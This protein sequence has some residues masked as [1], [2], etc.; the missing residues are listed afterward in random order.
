MQTKKLNPFIRVAEAPYAGRTGYRYTVACADTGREIASG[1]CESEAVAQ[2]MA[3]RV[4]K[5]PT[6]P[7]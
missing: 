5:V 7:E 1:W 6:K 3:D 4:A 2:Q